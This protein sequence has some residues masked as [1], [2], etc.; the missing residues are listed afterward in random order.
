MDL[1]D[2]MEVVIGKLSR[3][4]GFHIID[5]RKGK[6]RFPSLQ[7]EFVTF[8]TSDGFGFAPVDNPEDVHW[9]IH[10]RRKI[11]RQTP[12]LHLLL[13]FFE[14]PAEFHEKVKGKVTKKFGWRDGY[15]LFGKFVEERRK[16][17]KK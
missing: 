9:T 1:Y 4:A 12:L 7:G 10:T 16:D 11:P 17:H 8:L 5:A 13:P 6:V 15:R 3:K 14:D 2:A